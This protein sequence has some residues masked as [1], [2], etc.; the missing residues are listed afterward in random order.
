[1]RDDSTSTPMTWADWREAVREAAE[2][3]GRAMQQARDILEHAQGRTWEAV[4]MEAYREAMAGL[5]F[6]A[7]E[8]KRL[9]EGLVAERGEA[10]ERPLQQ[11]IADLRDL[12]EYV[13]LRTYGRAWWCESHNGTP[14]RREDETWNVEAECGEAES[15]DPVKAAEARLEQVQTLRR[16]KVLAANDAHPTRTEAADALM[17]DARAGSIQDAPKPE[18]AAEVAQAEVQDRGTDDTAPDVSVL[19]SGV[20]F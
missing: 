2:E 8:F 3:T 6:A 14:Y 12:H 13:S 1:M 17:T 19:N 18:P 20:A 4:G 7:G 16:E 15:P 10:Q 11:V 5:V 9:A